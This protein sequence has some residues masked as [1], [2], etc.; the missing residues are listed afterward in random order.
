MEGM[1]SSVRQFFPS[2]QYLTRDYIRERGL[3][4]FNM[5]STAS[6]RIYTRKVVEGGEKIGQKNIRKHKASRVNKNPESRSQKKET[7]FHQ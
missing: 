6:T 4:R 1:A 2:R 5:T 3:E 7:I